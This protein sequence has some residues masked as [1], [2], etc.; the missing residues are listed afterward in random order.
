M[1]DQ[2]VQPKFTAI[3]IVV[4][5]RDLCAIETLFHAGI[6]PSR[7]AGKSFSIYTPKII[8]HVELYRFKFS[9]SHI[10]NE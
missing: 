10:D 5:V 3:H 1:A 2:R 8:F 7:A 4:G 6:A 9:I